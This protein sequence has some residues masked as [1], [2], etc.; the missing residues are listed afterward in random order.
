[1]GWLSVYRHGI[2]P[3]DI[4]L[5]GKH[6]IQNSEDGMPPFGKVK[7]NKIGVPYR[8]MLTYFTLCFMYFLS[9]SKIYFSTLLKYNVHTIKF[10]TQ[11]H[12]LMSAVRRYNV[13]ITLQS[14]SRPLCRQFLPFGP[15]KPLICLLSPQFCLKNSFKLKKKFKARYE[16]SNDSVFKKVYRCFLQ[17]F[18]CVEGME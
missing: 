1:M 15:W 18:G 5:R 11:L 17:E 12:Y 13:S 16:Y 7:W 4:F 14:S 9:K 6:K 2:T 10:T 8:D 3:P